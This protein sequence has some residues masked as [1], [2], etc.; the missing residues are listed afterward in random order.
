MSRRLLGIQLVELLVALGMISVLA[1]V[2]LPMLTRASD[3]AR[4]AVCQANLQTIGDQLDREI[5]RLGCFPVLSSE[6]QPARSTRPLAELFEDDRLRYLVCPSD[7]S[8]NE[9]GHTSYRWFE[10][11]NGI[12]PDALFGLAELPLVV[13]KSSFHNPANNHR[14]ALLLDCD[15]PGQRTFI[16]RWVDGDNLVIQP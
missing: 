5:A 15:P 16:T 10:A 11:W 13:E 6:N 2:S 1:V 8:A 3:D 7:E 14:A 4:A 9:P 12:N